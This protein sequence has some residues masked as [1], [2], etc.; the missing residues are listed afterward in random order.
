MARTLKNE[1]VAT[2]T[3]SSLQVNNTYL[4]LFFSN[5]RQR[6]T[7]QIIRYLGL[8]RRDVQI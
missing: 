4:S 6:S 2:S 1:N 5:A 8:P 3:G 7:I